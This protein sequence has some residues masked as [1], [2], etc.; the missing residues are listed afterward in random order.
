M[1]SSCCGLAGIWNISPHIEVREICATSCASSSFATAFVRPRN[2]KARK[3]PSNRRNFRFNGWQ[4][5][6]L[7]V[8]QRL[9]QLAAT[10]FRRRFCVYQLKS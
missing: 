8:P 1:L 2:K 5:Q 4:N 6:G 9:L 7:A 10:I 3:E